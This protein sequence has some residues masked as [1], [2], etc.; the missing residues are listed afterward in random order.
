MWPLHKLCAVHQTEIPHGLEVFL[1]PQVDYKAFLRNN[2]SEEWLSALAMFS[3]E[4][5]MVST[6]QGIDARV[7]DINL[8]HK[9]AAYALYFLPTREWSLNF[10]TFYWGGGEE[11]AVEGRQH[12]A[13]LADLVH[14]PPCH[15]FHALV[16][17]G[18]YKLIS[19]ESQFRSKVQN[20][21]IIMTLILL[22]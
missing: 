9:W 6:M 4:E 21:K 18:S 20:K 17:L 2:M 16:R 5:K 3:I 11:V 13:G 1:T 7:T 15:W 22:K 12:I 10:Y 14:H 19:T 8:W